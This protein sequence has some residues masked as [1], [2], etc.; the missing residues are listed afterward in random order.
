[1]HSKVRFRAT[2]ASFALIAPW[3]AATAHAQEAAEA[4]PEGLGDIIVTAQKRAESLQDTPLA[5]SA[6]DAEM[7]R[8]RGIT[9]V[10]D[11]GSIAPNLVISETPSATANP[12]IAIR[13]I[14]D[15][16]PILTADPAVGLYVDGVIVGRSAG[17]LFDMMDLERIEVLRGPQGTL[18]G[19]NTT[20]GAVNMISAKPSDDFGGSVQM[21]YGRFDEFMAKAVLDTGELLDSG[22]ALKFGY[23]HSQRDGTVDN[24]FQPS[25]KRD[26][27]AR[28]V[29]ALRAALRFDKGTGFTLD[30]SYDFSDRH[31]RA[32]AFQL[33]AMRSDILAYLNFSPAFGGT[34]PLV[35]SERLS[36]IRLDR[37]GDVRDKVQGHTLTMNIEIGD[38][39]L[40]S[41]TGYREW[42][43]R[44]VS[45]DIDGNGGLVGFLVSPA[46][47]APPNPFIP[48]GIGPVDLFHTSNERHQN[49]ISQEL[50]L[51][52]SIGDE[53]DYV[54]GAY[55]FREEATE[56]NPQGFTLVLPSPVPIPIAPGISLNSFGVNVDTRL[57]YRHTSRSMAAFTQLTWKPAALDNR[58]S[59]TGGLRYTEDKKHLT[60]SSPIPPAP[61][62][63]SKKFNRLNWLAN[64]AYDWND[65]IMTYVRASTGYKAGGF[66]ARAA[67]NNG[68]DPEDLTSYEIGFKSDLFDRR[69]R[70]NLAAFHSIYD[71]LQVQQ[72]LA[73]TGG[74]ASTTVNAA[75]ATY[76]GIEAEL[77]VLITTGLTA[78]ASIGYTDRKYKTFIFVDPISG[79]PIDISDVAKFQYSAATTANVGAQYETALGDIGKL[80]A[81][82]DWSYRSK[83]YWHPINPFNEE[84][85][86]GGVGLLSGRLTLSEI[87][88][89]GSEA[90]VSLWGKNLTGEDYLLSGIDFGSL[91]FAGVMYGDPRSYGVE[92]AIKF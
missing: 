5:V 90:S 87:P 23:Y 34:A 43:N 13:G 58:L 9:S 51:I 52:G 86:D 63:L 62:D 33:R 21:G 12:S 30:Y 76:T 57:T 35:S 81:R 1:M 84:I 70:V 27:G 38:A 29:D 16:D 37:D 31:G 89:G 48:L 55:Y 61:R 83:I 49:Q 92:L 74:A 54:V 68:F 53:F 28:N 36:Q 22:V 6:V 69:V 72:F 80:T 60:Q 46:I 15:N 3:L 66:N 2:L 88:L 65:D 82:A 59:I 18:Y 11:I 8:E 24:V 77:Q 14:V 73:G 91:G 25:D 67:D 39:T 78:N 85:A 7:I 40:R 17:A 71:D 4:A 44:I 19:R 26:P 45:S 10:A 64:I 41:I 20:G 56:D 50:N 42:D 79:L 75:K 47:L 32:N